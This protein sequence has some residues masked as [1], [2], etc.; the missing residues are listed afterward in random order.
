MGN[1]QTVHTVQNRPCAELLT[2][3]AHNYYILCQADKYGNLLVFEKH[4][5]KY[6]FF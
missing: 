6:V 1:K 2:E 3:N 4:S 5:Q